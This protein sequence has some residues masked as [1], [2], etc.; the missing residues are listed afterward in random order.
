[1]LKR[2]FGPFSGLGSTV[3]ATAALHNFLPCG[4]VLFAASFLRL[5]CFDALAADASAAS[6]GEL[7]VRDG[8]PGGGNAA[9]V[10][11]EAEAIVLACFAMAVSRTSAPDVQTR[12]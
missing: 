7:L 1:M 3:A 5:R 8:G 2:M 9:V 6:A 11:L 10:F 4:R 12:E